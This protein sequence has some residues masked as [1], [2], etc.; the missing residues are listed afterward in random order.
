MKVE[1]YVAYDATGLAQEI[2]AGN[3]SAREVMQAAQAA[4]ES[5]N[6]EVNAIIEMFDQPLEYA[7]E[8]PFAGVPFLI[9]DIVLHAAGVASEAGSRLLAGRYVSGTDSE[10][11]TRFKRAG[12]ATFG[13]TATPEFGFNATTEPIL[14]GPTRNPWNLDHSSGGSSGGAAAAVA[15]GI[16]PVAHANDGGGSIRVPA[17]ACGLVGLM[18][19]RGRTPVGPDYNLPLYGLGIE[20]AVTRTVRDCAAL[21]DAV[22]GPEVG[23]MFNIPRPEGR[24]V[25]AIKKP[26]KRLRIAVAT[27]FPGVAATH[28]DCVAAVE[29]VAQELEHLGHDVEFAT[30]VY[31]PRALAISTRMAWSSFL[32][33]S[34]LGAA[35]A[36]GQEFDPRQVEACSHACID[37]G[38]RLSSLDVLNMLSQFNGLAR[39]VGMFFNDY[40]VL[41][42]PVT[43]FSTVKIGEMN[44]ND[45]E[46]DAVDWCQK[47]FDYCPFTGLFNITGTPAIA[48]P[49]AWSGDLPVGVQLAGPMGSETSLLQVAAT[50]EQSL[51]WGTRIPRIYAGNR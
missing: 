9:K 33:S 49:A 19:S 15:A 12:L 39:A 10:L 13:R 43:R 29:R 36:F 28:R 46:L 23:A 16:V 18:P 14:N 45:P 20:F 51:K 32:A 8:G 47:V 26:P 34:A 22:E 21:L 30:P 27:S 38:R 44:Q 37:Y 4:A 11:M 25:D 6:P 41:L 50:L 2:R 17:A 1:E 35:A 31:D 3:V 48:L 7:A 24:Y 40:D 5:V 42:T